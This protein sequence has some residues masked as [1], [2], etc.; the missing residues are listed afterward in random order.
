MVK[1]VS[2]PEDELENLK[3]RNRAQA[4]EIQRLNEV[5]AQKNLD[6]DALSFVWCDGGCPHG[7]HRYS[8][9]KLT[10]EMLERVERNTKRLRRWYNTVKWRLETYPTDQWHLNYA[11]R[12]AQRTDLLDNPNP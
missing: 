12:A 2:I 1:M 7:V 3:A 11:I 5:L 10:L 9:T 8:E 4:R 6:L